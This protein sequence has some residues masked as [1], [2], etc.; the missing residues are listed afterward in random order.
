MN[1][2]EEFEQIKQNPEEYIA[3][4]PYAA[5]MLIKSKIEEELYMK[6]YNDRVQELQNELADKG[7]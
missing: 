4:Y 5:N 6:M 1:I 7:E 2:I 3:V